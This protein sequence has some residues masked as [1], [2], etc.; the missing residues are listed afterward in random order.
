MRD[1]QRDAV[2]QA[3]ASGTNAEFVDMTVGFRDHGTCRGVDPND[4]AANSRPEEVHG[5]VF[6]PVGE[7]DFQVLP[8]L[9]PGQI[10]PIKL[11]DGAFEKCVSRSSFH[12]KS[13]GTTR[14]ARAI[15]GQL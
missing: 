13:G 3:R 1:A 8:N 4:P 9:D 11:F 10:C 7:G 5:V 12:P 2:T 14:Y 15:E 6:G